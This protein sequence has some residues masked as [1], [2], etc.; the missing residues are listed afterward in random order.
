M[1]MLHDGSDGFVKVDEKVAFVLGG[2]V[3]P[4][5]GGSGLMRVIV[6]G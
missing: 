4:L 3:W 1:Y 2:R 5:C 6:L